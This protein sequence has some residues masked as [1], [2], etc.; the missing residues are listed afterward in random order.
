MLPSNYFLFHDIIINIIFPRIISKR[1]FSPIL[2]F[3][4]L[5]DLLFHFYPYFL[6]KMQFS[7]FCL[8][9]L[10]TLKII[11]LYTKIILRWWKIH[12]DPWHVYFQG[13]IFPKARIS[14]IIPRFCVFKH[15]LD[16]NPV[17]K[18]YLQ[19]FISPCPK[20]KM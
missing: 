6:L 14:R 13:K 17:N 15:C 8:G 10:L 11:V 7:A 2:T 20:I 3:L 18:A 12:H 5:V 16:L 1:I 4:P 9:F 19:K